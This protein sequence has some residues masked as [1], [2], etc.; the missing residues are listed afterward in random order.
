[1]YSPCYCLDEFYQFY[2]LWFS[3]WHYI[4]LEVIFRCCMLLSQ[5]QVAW[6]PFTSMWAYPLGWSIT[7]LSLLIGCVNSCRPYRHYV[8]NQ[9]H[10]SPWYTCVS[11]DNMTSILTVHYRMTCVRKKILLYDNYG[12][13]SL[14]CEPPVKILFSS[15]AS[16]VFFMTSSRML[17]VR[18]PGL[19]HST[20]AVS[21]TNALW[22]CIH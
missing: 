10:L 12:H 11:Q 20:L 15:S 14:W 21:R 3:L 9:V 5:T 13:V 16:C 2:S 7:A 8:L 6:F 4:Q 1:M 18:S 17:S 19:V 22:S